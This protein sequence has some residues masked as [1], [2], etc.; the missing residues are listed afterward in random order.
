MFIFIYFIEYWTNV[1]KM[2]KSHE[3]LA[4]NYE[5]FYLLKFLFY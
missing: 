5:E 3:K 1:A 2:K 4:I